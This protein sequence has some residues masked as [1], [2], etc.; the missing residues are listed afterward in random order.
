[1]KM[2]DNPNNWFTIISAMPG[3]AQAIIAAVITA[4]LRVAY[5]K[6][7]KSWQRIGLEG[8]LCGCIAVGLYSGA[9]YLGLPPS[10]GV[11]IGSS[12][13]FVGVVQFRTFALKFIG[14]KIE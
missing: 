5:D 14:K 4:T 11:F 6:S 3:E 12:V 2:P 1:M 9:G 13:G 10:I 7:E 8:L